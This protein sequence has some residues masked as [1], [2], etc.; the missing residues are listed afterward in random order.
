LLFGAGWL[1]AWL[2]L[3]PE[4]GPPHDGD[5]YAGDLDP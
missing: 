5:G 1:M 3:G 4:N 2:F